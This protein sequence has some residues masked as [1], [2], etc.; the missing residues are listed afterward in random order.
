MLK[1]VK[2]S[3]VNMHIYVNGSIILHEGIE[4]ETSTTVCNKDAGGRKRMQKWDTRGM[5][6][7]E[8]KWVY[9]NVATTLSVS[10][11]SHLHTFNCHYRSNGTL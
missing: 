11:T 2:V 9:S 10:I 4:D 5:V 6:L 7:C 1:I 8:W 3:S